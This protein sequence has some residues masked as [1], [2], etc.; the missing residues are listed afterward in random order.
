VNQ[1][2][3]VHH[4]LK[5]QK[6]QLSSQGVTCRVITHPTSKEGLVLTCN[7]TKVLRRIKEPTRITVFFHETH[8]VID[9]FSP[10]ETWNQRL[11]AKTKIGGYKPGCSWVFREP[12]GRVLEILKENLWNLRVSSEQIVKYA[13]TS[14]EGLG[15]FH[16]YDGIWC[17]TVFPLFKG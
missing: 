13:K 17:T 4:S 11:F 3:P 9:F 15:F 1:H 16:K 2:P 6:P 10:Q 8:W 7:V 12:C 14:R 5:T